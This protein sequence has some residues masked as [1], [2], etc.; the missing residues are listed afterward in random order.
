MSSIVLVDCNNFFVSCERVFNPKLVGRPTV[1]L[2]NNDGCIIA[3]SQEARAL[4]IPMGAPL[5]KYRQYLN[6]HNVAICSSNYALYA[7]MSQRVMA[8]LQTFGLPLEIYSIDEAFLEVEEGENLDTLCHQIREKVFKWTGISVSVGAARTKTL[9]KVA[10]SFVK[11][12][13]TLQG[14]YI[15]TNQQ[16]QEI[17]K[18]FPVNKIWGIGKQLTTRLAKQNVHL[19]SELIKKPESWVR[20]YLTVVGLK[21]VYEL[22]GIASLQLDEL[23]SPK[24]SIMTSRS[25]RNPICKKEELL[26]QILHFVSKNSQKLRKENRLASWMQVFIMSSPHKKDRFY[27]NHCLTEFSEPTDYRPILLAQAKTLFEKIFS[28]GH[29]YKRA[30]VLFGGL[31]E[32]ESIQQS[33]FVQVD[34]TIIKKKQQTM[35]LLEKIN[36]KYKRPILRFASEPHREESK[37]CSAQFT[38]NW[39]EL[40]TIQI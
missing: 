28:S 38:T 2:S 6:D 4:Q 35:A 40:L 27:Q 9:A 5:F 14:V 33:L 10:G 30:G 12:D 31:I 15:P 34:P 36:Q 29:E 22:K 21:T 3:R 23:C 1:V 18:E 13:P 11:K 19:A 7:D 20:K 25:F 26:A 32:K 37:E 16:M 8:T 17:L 24:Q 39:N